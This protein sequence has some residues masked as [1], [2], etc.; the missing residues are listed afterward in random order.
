M[1]PELLSPFTLAA[2]ALLA[3]LGAV[4]RSARSADDGPTLGQHAARVGTGVA[5]RASGLTSGLGRLATSVTA[6]TIELGGVAAGGVIR[7]TGRLSSTLSGGSVGLVG[8]GTARTGGLLVDGLT[9]LADTLTSPL[10][11]RPTADAPHQTTNA[12]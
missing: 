10:R 12:H 9:A 5:M 4:R 3:A 8:D 1:D 11:P 2:G 6:G 7:G